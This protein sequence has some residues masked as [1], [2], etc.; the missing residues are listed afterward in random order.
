MTSQVGSPWTPEEDA[1]LLR[2]YRYGWRRVALYVN[3]SQ[4]GIE[5]RASELAHLVKRSTY[6]NVPEMFIPKESVWPSITR[7]TRHLR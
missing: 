2:L 5:K 3:R 7:C 6:G 4:S 1:H